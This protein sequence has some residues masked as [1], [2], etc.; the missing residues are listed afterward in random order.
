MMRSFTTLLSFISVIFF[1]WPFTALLALLVSLSEPLVP[2]AV[3]IFADTLYYDPSA[4]LFPLFTVCG[5]VATVG[6]LFIR[7]RLRRGPVS[8]I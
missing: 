6:A 7:S 8:G 4:S 3:G 2:L 5:G 1:P